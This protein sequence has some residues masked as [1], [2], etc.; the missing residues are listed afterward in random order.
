MKKYDFGDG[1]NVFFTSDTHFY[2][3]AI[4]YMCDRPFINEEE[5]NNILIDNWNKVVGKND[6]VF[7]LGD[8]CFGGPPKWINVLEKLNGHIYLIMGNHDFKNLKD[9]VTQYF[10]DVVQQMR[11]Q[12]DGWTLYL[13]HYPYLCYGGAWNTDRKVGEVFGHVHSGP[14][15]KGKDFPRLEHLFSTQYDVGVDNN[16]YKPIS[17]KEVKQIF[18]KRINNENR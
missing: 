13:N 10:V 3:E 17:W 7:H 6:I 16:N 8:F 5:M 4:I 12:I 14:N 11:I 15:C 18:E 1:S 9:N 2:H